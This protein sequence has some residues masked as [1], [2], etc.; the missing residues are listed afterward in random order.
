[1]QCGGNYKFI[2]T[3]AVYRCTYELSLIQHCIVFVGP[4]V[5]TSINMRAGV[6][7]SVVVHADVLFKAL[8]CIQEVVF[9]EGCESTSL[10]GLRL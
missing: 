7:V 10:S 9:R 3:A 2:C 6:Q 5:Y 1:M 4:N 8:C